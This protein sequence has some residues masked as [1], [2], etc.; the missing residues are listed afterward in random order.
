MAIAKRIVMHTNVFGTKK[1]QEKRFKKVYEAIMLIPFL[2]G[3]E[4]EII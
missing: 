2:Y 1:T 4:S 3:F